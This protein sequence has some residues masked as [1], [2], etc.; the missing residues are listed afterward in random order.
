MN[1]E[2]RECRINIGRKCSAFII[3]TETKWITGLNFGGTCGD[4]NYMGPA[5]HLGK[6]SAFNILDT[7]VY[8]HCHLQLQYIQYSIYNDS[9]MSLNTKYEIYLNA[10]FSVLCLVSFIQMK[11]TLDNYRQL[12]IYR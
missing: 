11:K 8:F 4:K 10:N 1:R 6:S 2:C 7:I 9:I 5:S 3:W 12:L